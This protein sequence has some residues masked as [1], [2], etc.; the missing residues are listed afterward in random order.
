M[1]VW[2]VFFKNALTSNGPLSPHRFPYSSPLKN[3]L[4]QLD[5]IRFV[6]KTRDG[7]ADK[8]SLRSLRRKY[9]ASFSDYA[10][11]STSEYQQAYRERCIAMNEV[12]LREFVAREGAM[13]G[14][15]SERDFAQKAEEALASFF[16]MSRN[17]LSLGGRK[18][19]F[20][21]PQE[22]HSFKVMCLF[23]ALVRKDLDSVESHFLSFFGQ[24]FS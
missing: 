23:S 5:P 16:A 3:F 22:F 1:A 9:N 12:F 4:L 18:A 6:H 2:N 20:A 21:S 10:I 14:V 19:M 11:G 7:L 15:R 17:S 13:A 8:N 24:S